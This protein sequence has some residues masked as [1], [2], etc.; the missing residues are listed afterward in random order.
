MMGRLVL[1]GGGHA[2]LFVLEAAAAGRFQGAD[3]VLVS[4]TRHQA[5]SGLLPALVAGK[6][7]E[8]SL[9]FDLQRLAERARVRFLEDRVEA[10]DPQARRV[11]LASGR[12]EDYRTLSFATGSQAGGL[13]VP[14]VRERALPL[15]PLAR[16]RE[17]LEAA[18]A[19]PDG[20]HVA[21]VGGGAAGIEVACALRR[22]L[23]VRGHVAV[24]D[25]APRLLADRAEEASR[26]AEAELR[27][28]SIGVAAGARVLEV[29][30][31]GLRLDSGAM[32]PARLVVWAV[33]GAAPSL[34]RDAGLATDGAG[35]LQVDDTLRSV[36]HPDIF[37]AG[38]AATLAGATWVP[39]AGVYAVRQG[40]VL[41]AN[42]AAVVAGKAPPR[43]YRPRRDF[44]ALLSLADGS[45]IFSRGTTAFASPFAQRLKD[46][47]DGRFMRRFQRL[48][49]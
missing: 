29:T 10:V 40:P 46:W 47:I 35:W 12:V 39:K 30:P 2:H 3:I 34:F 37:A 5:Y 45:A 32:V 22:R 15:R 31:T 49:G 36:S 4:P 24:V 13:E 25:A 11:R 48:G 42:L 38:D 1:A 21:V 44:V 41:A 6:L 8:P 26:V 14:G 18:D 9:S 27:R 16:V 17:L 23:G 19:A 20:I 43:R 7:A 28:R 33:G